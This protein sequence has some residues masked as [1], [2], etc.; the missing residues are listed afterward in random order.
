[1]PLLNLKNTINS[2]CYIKIFPK[3][4][5][6]INGKIHLMPT[7]IKISTSDHFFLD[8]DRLLPSFIQNPKESLKV[9]LF[10]FLPVFSRITF[11]I[12]MIIPN[13]FLFFDRFTLHCFRRTSEFRS[14]YFALL[15]K[16]FCMLLL[17]I[18]VI[19]KRIMFL[20]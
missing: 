9:H 7:K 3:K 2:K 17:H 11:V 13:L 8:F 10:I 4:Y 18:Q 20:I 15:S 16:E 6:D 12:Y 19:S 14:L 5:K 1:M